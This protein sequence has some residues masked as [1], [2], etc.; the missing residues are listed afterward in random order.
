LAERAPGV[1]GT[2]RVVGI[3]GWPVA[4]SLSP[5]IHN[6]AFGSS[7][8]DWIYVPLPVPV[9]R[10]P[11]ALDGL[12]ALG[13]AG[14]NVTMPHKSTCAARCDLLSDD[15]RR[16]SAVNTLVIEDDAVHGY[17]TDAPGFDRFL[18][19]DIGFEP[20]GR[21][22]LVYGAGGAAR[23]VALSLARGGLARLTVVVRDPARSQDLRSALDGLPT[24]VTVIG[25]DR[26]GD[27]GVDL[28]VNATPLDGEGG[29]LPLP[30]LGPDVVV[31]DLHYV[32]PVTPFQAEARAAGAR[33]FGGLGL[34]LHQAAI[35]FELWTGAPAPLETMSAAALGALAEPG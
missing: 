30:R 9:G 24:E 3:I 5:A 12:V 21:T 8:L 25:F 33:V 22:A 26:A 35:A 16:L 13:F 19:R 32:P 6:A 15:A 34:L 4:H 18:R 10:V 1:G 27:A 11:E 23:A 2:S 7:G 20:P 17:N 28:A 29:S 14:A 31:V